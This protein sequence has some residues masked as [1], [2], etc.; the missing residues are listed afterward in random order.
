LFVGDRGMVKGPQKK[1]LKENNFEY[2][3][4]IA[5]PQI[6]K[7]ISNDII[8]LQLFDEDMEEVVFED[9]RY[10]FRR[11]PVRAKEVQ[12][13]RQERITKVKEKI[14]KINTIKKEL[15][16][17]EKYHRGNTIISNYKLK[18]VLTLEIKDEKVS[19]SVNKNKLKELEELDGCYVMETDN[20]SDTKEQ[21]HSYYK[22]LGE[23]EQAFKC[24]KT[25]H[26]E[27][28]PIFHRNE[29][30]IRAHV[31]ITMLSYVLLHQ[32]EKNTAGRDYNLSSIIEQF[33]VLS[34]SMLGIGEN[35]FQKIPEKLTRIQADVLKRC[36]FKI[37]L[38]NLV[39]G[40]N[41]V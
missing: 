12:N 39:V 3:T 4:A 32:L 35:V 40:K 9:K 19:T 5:A 36:K 22:Q 8:Q 37:K 10:I 6:R 14:E 34:A 18:N 30:R 31:F 15:S 17:E 16:E 38:P 21:L 1:E 33:K 7:L 20:K 28:R 27:L 2:L 26:L 23:V 13:N 25:Q 24:I 29:D 11:N 41:Q